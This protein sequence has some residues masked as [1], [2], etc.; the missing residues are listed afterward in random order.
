MA[1]VAGGAYARR[2]ANVHGC[3][4]L[5]TFSLVLDAFSLLCLPTVMGNFKCFSKK[6]TR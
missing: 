4:E 6:K 5:I 3:T 1:R 2:D